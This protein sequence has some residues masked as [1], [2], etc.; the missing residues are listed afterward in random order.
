M[1]AYGRS[2][3]GQ[4]L[5]SFA[6][7]VSQSA[8]APCRAVD[9]FSKTLLEDFGTNLDVQGRRYLERI[10]AAVRMGNLIDE[11]F[12]SPV[13]TP[14][15]ASAYRH[16]LV[17]ERGRSRIATGTV[18]IQAGL[19]AEAGRELVRTVLQNLLANAYK[20]TS[21]TSIHALASLI[22]TAC[23]S[24]TWPT[25]R[26]FLHGPCQG[27]AVFGHFTGFT[28][29][30]SFPAT[31]IGLAPWRDV[32]TATGAEVWA[33]GAV[34][35]GATFYFSLIPGARMPAAAPTGQGMIPRS[36]SRQTENNAND[37][38]A[39]NVVAGRGQPG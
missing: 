15:R 20:F 5:E 24:T 14:L 37:R 1:A 13:A 21:K 36:G 18:E 17:G 26:R 19:F 2:Q 34:N 12:S 11:S 31:G 30:A 3:A 8:R 6:Y 38:R 10:T 32:F 9:G 29:R 35:Q 27:T 33:E 23:W 4:Q 39:A 16:E 28:A 7:S 22:S 25:T